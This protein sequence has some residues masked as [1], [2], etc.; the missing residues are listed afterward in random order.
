MKHLA[1]TAKTRKA[2]RLHTNV[3]M[4]IIISFDIE[5]SIPRGQ[6]S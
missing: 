4:N 5:I 6:S 2:L 3:D 1:A